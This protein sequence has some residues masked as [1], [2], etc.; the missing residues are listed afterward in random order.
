M[1]VITYI[2]VC[3]CVYSFYNEECTKATNS[4]K[5]CTYYYSKDGI[6]ESEHFEMANNHN[7]GKRMTTQ[8][9]GLRSDSSN[10][11]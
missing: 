8:K 11:G 5:L 3:V 9:Q 10:D 2:C 6:S 1:Y 7:Y 4:S